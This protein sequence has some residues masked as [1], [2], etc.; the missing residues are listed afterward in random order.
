MDEVVVKFT[1]PKAKIFE[2]NSKGFGLMH[3]NFYTSYEKDVDNRLSKE[4]G[5][6]FKLKKDCK[7]ND[8]NFNVTSNEFS[9]L[10]FRLNIYKVENGLPTELISDKDIVFEI[11]DEFIGWFNLDLKHYNIYLDKD[12]EDIECILPMKYI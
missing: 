5:M 8:L 4:I 6:K 12:S 2:R 9:S 3:F 10:K 1:K 7:I 11:K